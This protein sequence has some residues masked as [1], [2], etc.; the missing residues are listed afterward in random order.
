MTNLDMKEKTVKKIGRYTKSAEF[1]YEFVKG[2]STAAAAMCEWVRAMEK[3]YEI[4]TKVEPLRKKLRGAEKDL[5]VKQS[6]LNAILKELEEVQAVLTKL[7]E[8]FDASEEIK[9]KLTKQANDL[10]MKLSRANQLITGL[11]GEK[12][13]WE[14][15]IGSFKESLVTITGDCAVA[16]S[17]MSNSFF[18]YFT[19]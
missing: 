7:Q 3:F 18:N 6:A 11:S 17:F 1:T 19:C 16:A 9:N 15:S 12:G 10:E 8:E 5:A 13:R 4:N 2:K 14:K